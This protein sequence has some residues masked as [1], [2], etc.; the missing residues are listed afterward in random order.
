MVVPGLDAIDQLGHEMADHRCVLE[1][2]AARADGHVEA[3]EV[4]AVVDRDPVVGH[5]VQVDQALALVRDPQGRH[6]PRQAVDLRLPLLLGHVALELVGVVHPDLRVALGVL[7]SYP[8]R[9]GR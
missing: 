4:G 5:V 9:S 8:E 1:L 6:P 3:V 7:L 2:V